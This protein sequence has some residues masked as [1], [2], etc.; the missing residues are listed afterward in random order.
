MAQPSA[1]A[2]VPYA[3]VYLLLRTLDAMRMPVLCRRAGVPPALL[4]QLLALRWAGPEARSDDVAETLR[5]IVGDLAAQHGS[6]TADALQRL[7]AEV[8]RI[9]VT[10]RP[11]GGDVVRLRV[12]PFGTTAMAMVLGDADDLMWP[13][14]QI[15]R[16]A[17]ASGAL[18]DWWMEVTGMPAARVEQLPADADDPGRAVLLAALAGVAH[19]HGGD[20]EVDLP[21]DLIALTL[22]REWARW[23][24]G[25]SA[26]SVPYLLATFV[27]RPG[28]LIDGSGGRLRVSLDGL[29]HDIVLDVSGCLAAFE[30]DGHGFRSP[31]PP[32]RWVPRDRRRRAAT[33]RVHHGDM[34]AAGY[35]SSVEHLADELARVDQLVRAQTERW[36]QSIAA[37]KPDDAWGMAYVDDAEVERYL[38]APFRLAHGNEDA[39]TGENGPSRPW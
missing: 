33:D 1:V 39:V 32:G 30:P 5:P 28:R 16:S 20:P 10:Q 6:L 8:A 15:Q 29:P 22:V 21:L 2:D 35:A 37:T 31:P 17:G 13:G 11:G 25:F 19:A 7:Q 3:G 38:T 34:M 14:G 27:R 18:L 36:R 12:V 23:L 9:V 26:A 4:L 24:R